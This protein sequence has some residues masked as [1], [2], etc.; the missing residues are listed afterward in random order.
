MKYILIVDDEPHMTYVLKMYLERNGYAVQT[1]MNGQAAM[2]SILNNA[3]DALITDIQMPV[4]TG[5]QLCL[6]L[7]AQYAQRTFPIFVMTSMTNQ[8]HRDWAQKI[9][10]LEFLEK[11]LS[12]RALA[13]LLDKHFSA[14]ETAEKRDYA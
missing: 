11:P 7:E 12:M 5:K 10:N 4:M 6:T 3:P 14:T 8:E 1:A 13:R 9:P 2:D